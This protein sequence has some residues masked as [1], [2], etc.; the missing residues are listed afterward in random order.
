M[1]NNHLNWFDPSNRK[2]LIL[3]FEEDY[4][5]MIGQAIS[6][7]NIEVNDAIGFKND[8]VYYD[9]L[10]LKL[11]YLTT[12]NRHLWKHHFLGTQGLIMIFSFHSKENDER[13]IF[14]AINVFADKNIVGLPILVLV[15][16]NNPDE[17]IIEK[18]RSEL[19]QSKDDYSNFVKF[20]YIDF[21][22]DINELEF[23][24]EWLCETMKPLD[25]K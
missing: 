16:I 4:L 12:K 18:L 1:G 7:I 24:L 23:G 22:N 21:K 14:E 8:E 11:Y 13:I 15:D 20:Q 25:N 10:S 6:K 17:G 19:N 5:Q 2:I 3:S 9:K